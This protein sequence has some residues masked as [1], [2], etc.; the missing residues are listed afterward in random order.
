MSEAPG[1]PIYLDPRERGIVD[2]NDESIQEP[3]E[4]HPMNGAAEKLCRCHVALGDLEEA[5]E[6]C[7]ATRDPKKRRRRMR[8]ASVPLHNLCVGIVDTINAIQSDSDRHSFMA[9]SVPKD[10]TNL[11]SRFVKLVP[12]DR[13]GKLGILR[14]RVSAHLDGAESPTSMREIARSVETTEFGEW[15]NICVAVMCDL[16]RLDAYAWTASEAQGNLMT[17]MY[18]EPL[19]TV[20][21]VE[22]GSPVNIEGFFASKKSPKWDV[23]ERVQSLCK[24]AQGLFEKE[25][26]YQIRNFYPDDGS[27]GWS[28]VLRDFE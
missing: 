5:V 8:A 26:A 11:R 1:F 17:I 3:N 2:F 25:S 19:I 28:S 21:R 12:F 16:I 23:G 4:W 18:Q 20:F 24:L 22:D 10:L 27:R 15:I 13:K 9:S 14:N 6:Q 7:L